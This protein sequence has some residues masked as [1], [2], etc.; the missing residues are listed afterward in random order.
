MKFR[1]SMAVILLPLIDYYAG[2]ARRQ[3]S[4]CAPTFQA[5]LDT[6]PLLSYCSLDGRNDCSQIIVTT[7]VRRLVLGISV[8]Q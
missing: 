8:V 4:R 3:P 2:L 5:P 7:M 6:Q 1:R